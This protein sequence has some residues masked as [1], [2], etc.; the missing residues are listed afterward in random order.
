MKLE[1][2]SGGLRGTYFH[3][4][5]E[6]VNLHFRLA[7]PRPDAGPSRAELIVRAIRAGVDQLLQVLSQRSA[8]WPVVAYDEAIPLDPTRS[9]CR[10]EFKVYH[11]DA[12]LMLM[13]VCLARPLSEDSLDR[14]RDRLN[15]VVGNAVAVANE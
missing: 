2:S 1:G 15:A 3:A 5:M 14:L 11:P 6:T 13:R 8:E 12:G 10:L 7:A 9:P 4:S